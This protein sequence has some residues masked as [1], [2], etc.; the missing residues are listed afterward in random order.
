MNKH[1]FE[2]YTLTWRGIDIE[3]TCESKWLKVQGYTPCHIT[4]RSSFPEHAALPLTSV[5]Y[6]FHVTDPVDVVEAGR[7]FAFV[8]TELD[9]AAKSRKNGFSLRVQPSACAVLEL[10]PRQQFFPEFVD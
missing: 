7:P 4:L 5:G 8:T 3:I 9:A 6:K 2:A 10:C 1:R